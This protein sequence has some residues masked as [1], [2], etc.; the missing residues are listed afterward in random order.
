MNPE[1]RLKL[2][3]AQI[4]K[5]AYERKGLT[6]KDIAAHLKC[7]AKKIKLI[8]IEENAGDLYS[9]EQAENLAELLDINEVVL[10]KIEAKLYKV[11]LS[12]WREK[13]NQGKLGS[14]AKLLE[15]Y[16]LDEITYLP[17]DIN[18]VILYKMF[19]VKFLMAQRKYDLA[20]EL[21]SQADISKMSTENKYH[22][23][24]NKGSLNIYHKRYDAA[25]KYYTNAY[26]TSFNDE[27]DYRHMLHFN[28]GLCY[29]RMGMCFRAINSLEKADN[30]VKR[31]AGSP[32]PMFLDNSLAMNYMRI[33]EL[34]LAKKRLV[35][36]LRHAEDLRNEKYIGRAMHNLGCLCI[37]EKE[38]NRALDY[39]DKA[40]MFMEQGDDEYLENLYYRILC[41]IMMKS[42]LPGAEL[43]RAKSISEE[44][45]NY[46]FLFN[47][48][49]HLLALEQVFSSKYIE[50]ETIPYLIE[51]HEYYRIMEYY[52]VMESFF[53][54][55]DNKAKASEIKLASYDIYKKI[56][57]GDRVYEKEIDWPM[58]AFNHDN[59]F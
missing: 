28:L 55:N 10:D 9:K 40:N 53:T 1:Q 44:S 51:R 4:I 41:L 45:D 22:Y 15:D 25:L 31:E 39:F 48:L 11:R 42:P 6:Q 23:F 16:S 12:H 59:G 2:P 7:T 8:E 50:S 30:L 33:G 19:Y 36:C 17:F 27:R 57:Q 35:D 58:L 32:F 5:E 3:I 29:S 18:L 43:T 47:S 52:E 20:D 49:S 34:H 13:I 21:L 46:Q 37:K 26:E 54:E 56:T 14:A 24:Y 38:Y